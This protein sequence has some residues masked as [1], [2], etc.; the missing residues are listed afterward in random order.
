MYFHDTIHQMLTDHDRHFVNQI[1]EVHEFA[2]FLEEKIYNIICVN[3]DED[4]FLDVEVRDSD[5]LIRGDLIIRGWY[6]SL[7]DMEGGDYITLQLDVHTTKRPHYIY[8]SRDKWDFV[9]YEIGQV[10]DHEV[11]HAEQRAKRNYIGITQPKAATY[12]ESYYGSSDEMEAYAYNTAHDL[13]RHTR[14]DFSKAIQLLRNQSLPSTLKT[15][16]ILKE[17]HTVFYTTNPRK[18]KKFIKTTIR[19]LERINEAK[20]QK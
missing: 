20:N 9:K 6:V 5:N 12:R 1:I 18:W 7:M 19:F 11:I 14:G 13:L 2:K 16:T 15:S 10:I 17:Y 3:F 4:F 8:M